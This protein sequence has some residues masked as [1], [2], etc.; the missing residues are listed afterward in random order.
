MKCESSYNHIHILKL[1]VHDRRGLSNARPHI[2]ALA[3][4]LLQHNKF[5]TCPSDLH[6]TQYHSSNH[7]TLRYNPGK[8]SL[9][10]RFVMQNHTTYGN[11]S[12]IVYG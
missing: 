3:T 12:V 11:Q 2:Y 5:K 8:G 9:N 1:F 10:N 7:G 6:I 4:K